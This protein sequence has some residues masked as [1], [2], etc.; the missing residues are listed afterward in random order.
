MTNY[1]DAAGRSTRLAWLPTRKQA[2]VPRTLTGA[3]NQ[4]AT[5]GVDYDQQSSALRIRDEVNRPVET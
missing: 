2:S 3:T 1:T 4:E 5:I